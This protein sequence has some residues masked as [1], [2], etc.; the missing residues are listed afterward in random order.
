MFERVMARTG[1]LSRLRALWKADVDGASKPLRKDVR[2]FASRLEA[3]EL[4]LAE[5][6]QRAQRAD[7]LA[8]VRR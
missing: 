6:S 8:S 1:V 5:A 4:Q 2:Q 3:V 7:R